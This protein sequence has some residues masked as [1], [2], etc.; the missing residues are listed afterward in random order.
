M[1]IQTSDASSYAQLQ[2][3]S[4]NTGYGLINFGDG[5]ASSPG[6]IQYTHSS[7]LMLLRATKTIELK[8]A[9]RQVILIFQRI[10]PKE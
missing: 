7:D 3:T 6:Y 1:K 4:P 2:F 8:G 5:D 10:I 9:M